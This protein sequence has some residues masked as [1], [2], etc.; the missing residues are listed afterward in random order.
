MTSLL[1][2]AIHVLLVVIHL[3][4]RAW[5]PRVTPEDALRYAYLVQQVA[6]IMQSRE[7]ERLE[8]K[9]P[10]EIPLGKGMIN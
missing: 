4:Y 7:V 1:S 2:F 10:S 3:C 9:K 8:T 6:H 5:S